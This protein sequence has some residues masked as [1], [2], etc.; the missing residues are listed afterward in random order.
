MR[1]ITRKG[2]VAMVVIL[3]VLVGLTIGVAVLG[4]SVTNVG[5]S[6][7]EEERARSFSAAEAGVEDAL[8]QDLSILAGSGGNFSVGNSAV[9]YTVAKLTNVV[10]EINPGEVVTIN[11]AKSDPGANSFSA[12]WTNG[13][14]GSVALIST[15]IT[16]LA[17]V[18]HASFA[19]GPQTFNKGSG[20]L[21]RLRIAGCRSKVTIT[22]QGGALSFFQVDSKGTSGTSSS[23]VQVV[24]SAPAAS[25]LLD[26]ALFSGGNID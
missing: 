14:C 22:G 21:V 9:S 12:A 26:F 17:A 19:T 15:T 3:V 24:R 18:T 6:L 10:S 1:F 11:W 2:Q 25:G 23:K 16:P 7:Q 20:G 13:S 8:R 5:I 4:R